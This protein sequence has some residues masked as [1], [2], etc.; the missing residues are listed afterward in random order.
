MKPSS[1]VDQPVRKHPSRTSV[2]RNLIMGCFKQPSVC[3]NA[4][5]LSR[6]ILSPTLLSSLKGNQW[7]N[8]W[9]AKCV[10][11]KTCQYCMLSFEFL[12]TFFFCRGSLNKPRALGALDW[13]FKESSDTEK[14]IGTSDKISTV[15]R[16]YQDDILPSEV[17]LCCISN[18][19]RG[20]FKQSLIT[21]IIGM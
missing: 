8:K 5:C 16:R 17:S 13:I 18:V 15:V 1:Q 3:G 2:H 19:H 9:M 10:R 7:K 12:I 6:M 4:A 21:N 11:F 20:A 14:D